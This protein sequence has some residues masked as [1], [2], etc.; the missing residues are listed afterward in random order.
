LRIS[1]AIFKQNEKTQPTMSDR[2]LCIYLAK[3]LNYVKLVQSHCNFKTSSKCIS[4]YGKTSTV[5]P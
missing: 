3:H 2:Y 1:Q 4:Y 5:I